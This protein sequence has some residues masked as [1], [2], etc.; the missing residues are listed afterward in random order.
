MLRTINSNKNHFYTKD[1]EWIEYNGQVAYVGVCDF[2]LIGLKKIQKIEYGDLSGILQQ[3]HVLATIFSDEYRIMM[4]MPVTGKIIE[5][6]LKLLTEPEMILKQAQKGG[7]IAKINPSSP[8][9]RNGLL[10]PEQ[11][12][13]SIKGK[14]HHA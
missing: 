9:N 7:W 2:K 13:L 6:N 3:G 4:H 14:Y 5:Y 12:Q 8:Y 10:Q 1:H 11:Y